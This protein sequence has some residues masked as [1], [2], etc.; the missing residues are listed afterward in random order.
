M[1]NKLQ[2]LAMNLYALTLKNIYPLILLICS[3]GIYFTYYGTPS[4]M[5]WDENYHIASAQKH[6]DGVMYM[7]PHPP[8][9]KMLMALAEVVIDPNANLD[10]QKFNY[11]DHIEGSDTPAGIKFTG[12]RWPSVVLMA[13]SVLFFYGILR[14]ITQHQLLAFLFS[15]FIIF[16]NALVIQARAAMLE[17][18]QLFFVLAELYCFVYVVTRGS[19]IRLKDYAFLGV[20]IGLGMSVKVTSAIELL[21]F[22]MLF[23]VDQ[24]KNIQTYNY[25]A[26][27]KRLIITVPTGVVPLALVF[28]SVFYIHIGMG[29]KVIAG[30]TYKASPEYLQAIQRGDTWSPSTF[31]IGMRDNFKYMSEYAPGVP[32]L[33][34]CKPDENGSYAMDWL[35]GKKTISYRWD[36]D[37]VNGQV[38]VKY[39]NIVANPIIWFSVLAGI[40]LSLGLIMSK[41]IYGQKEKNTPLFYWICALTS[42][43]M[44]YMIAILQIE[45]VMYIYHYLV[46]LVFGMLNL[47]L[48]FSYIYREDILANNKHLWINLSLYIMLVIGVFAF[49]APFTYGI[50]MTED[51]FEM[52]NWFSFWK[53]QVVR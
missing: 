48:V 21:L 37:T 30:K 26:L 13:L 43:Y 46:P 22:V 10:K 25:R 28:L 35:L 11:T 2:H 27:A 45:R 16:D 19:P 17:G 36:K 18:I 4:A 20:V 39:M 49:F 53:L 51:Q 52:R 50:G 24:W 6:I 32:K 15:S 14:R 3:F 31:V 8:L 23:G 1:P 47:A 12:Y 38:E 7:E 33:D 5:F 42:L 29:T 40:V 9:G 41:F 44:C 34:E